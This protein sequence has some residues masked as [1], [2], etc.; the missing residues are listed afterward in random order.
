MISDV[1]R[2]VR[3]LRIPRPLLYW[4]PGT[5]AAVL[6]G[7]VCWQVSIHRDYQADILNL[8]QINHQE[9][10]A[11]QQEISERDRTIHM[12][13]DD[14]LSLGEQAD[15]VQR[16]L[17]EIQALEEELRGISGVV[18][19]EDTH[20]DNA[21]EER[22]LSHVSSRS[23]IQP[24]ALSVGG[25]ARLGTSDQLKKLAQSISIS[26]DNAD[27]Q[28]NELT[29]KLEQAK[30]ALLEEIEIRKRTP[31]LWPTAS[32]QVTSGFGFRRDPFTGRS[33]HHSGI[34]IADDSGSTIVATAKGKVEEEGWDS[35]KGNYII[36]AHGYGIRTVYMHLV[37]INVSKGQQ[38]EKGEAIG[39][40]G[41]TGRST[42]PHLHY[43]VHA[44]QKPVNPAPFLP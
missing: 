43:E 42:G 19:G 25:E 8:H 9:A 12:L 33:T 28:M 5:C 22:S 13:Q 16:Q 2:P 38:V 11:Y 21:E 10:A 39:K 3:S 40:M 35:Q 7:V 18:E 37:K 31:S 6:I 41:S 26:M 24:T 1:D 44:H 30:A 36:I 20:E 15:A 29:P 17:D 23:S 32:R 14:L 4:I 34:D 27:T